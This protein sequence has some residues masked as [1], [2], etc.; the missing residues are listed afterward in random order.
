[1]SGVGTTQT[2]FKG[3]ANIRLKRFIERSQ[4][5]FQMNGVLIVPGSQVAVICFYQAAAYV[6][7]SSHFH[8]EMNLYS[9]AQGFVQSI[10]VNTNNFP[11]KAAIKV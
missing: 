4:T 11:S 1:M 6:S 9:D 7:H 2:L 10:H 3:G 8:L 5:R